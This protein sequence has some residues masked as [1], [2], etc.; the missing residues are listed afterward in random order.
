MPARKAGDRAVGLT[1][2]PSSFALSLRSIMSGGFFLRSPPCRL[3]HI[4]RVKKQPGVH[5]SGPH[6]KGKSNR[7]NR[8]FALDV[9]MFGGI[10]DSV[11]LTVDQRQST[12]R[13]FANE[14]V[15]AVLRAQPDTLHPHLPQAGVG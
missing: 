9:K 7:Q 11:Q 13:I 15:V 4:R 14:E 8:L 2:L 5:N 1:L 12:P 6:P 10:R 3:Q